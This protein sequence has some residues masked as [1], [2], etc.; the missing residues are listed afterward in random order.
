M[1]KKVLSLEALLA[2]EIEYR[3]E[4]E[5]YKEKQKLPSERELALEYGV[6]RLTMRRALQILVQKRCLVSKERSGYFV[7]PKR[8]KIT[9]NQYGSITKV[10]EKMGKTS[11]IKLLEFDKMKLTDRL[12]E[13]TMLAEG[14]EVYRLL[15]L[16]YENRTPVALEKSYI[17]YELA[18]DLEEGDVHEKSLYDTLK[19]KYG[20]DVDHSNQ[21]VS[22]V[23]ANG[24]EAELL[25]VGPSKPL[26]KYQGLVY[27]KKGRL[28]EYF[29]NIMLIERIEFTSKK[30]KKGESN[31]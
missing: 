27:D 16:R 23:H 8:I 30:S 25:K 17:I 22:V 28:I 24:L 18:K 10:I 15:R 20:L 11:N 1:R 12:A 7:A 19:R 29:E 4:T 21:R 6:Q 9:L 31:E 13:K 2:K 3:L 5:E 26:M 14:T